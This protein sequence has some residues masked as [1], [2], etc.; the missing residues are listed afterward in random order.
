MVQIIIL[1]TY[2]ITARKMYIDFTD[3]IPQYYAFIQALSFGI[4]IKLILLAGHSI[5]CWNHWPNHPLY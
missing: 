4:L 5:L 3:E 2:D 1:I